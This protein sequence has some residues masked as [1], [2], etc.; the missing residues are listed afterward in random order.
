MHNIFQTSEYQETVTDT[1]K[2]KTLL[3]TIKRTL[4]AKF[5]KLCG[6]NKGLYRGYPFLLLFTVFALISP[7]SQVRAAL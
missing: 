6:I 3:H 5:P 7:G 1:N 4:M 2:N